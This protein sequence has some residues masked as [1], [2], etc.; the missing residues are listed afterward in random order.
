RRSHRSRR[1][2]ATIN[3]TEF[4]QA[5]LQIPEHFNLALLGGRGGGK[6]TG[7][8]LLVLRHCIKYQ[9]RARPLIVRETY[10]SLTEIEDRLE[11]LFAVAF[12]GGGVQH[13]RADH[14]FRLPNGA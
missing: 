10:K 13:N 8:L 4:Q 7:A 2:A 6:T 5:V 1:M 14:V 11:A 9:D 3:P 12:P